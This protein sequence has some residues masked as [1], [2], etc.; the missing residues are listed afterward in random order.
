MPFLMGREEREREKQIYTD[1]KENVR[2]I[3]TRKSQKQI[4]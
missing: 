4:G 3:L 2:F 1:S